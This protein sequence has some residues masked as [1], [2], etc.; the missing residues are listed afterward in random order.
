METPNNIQNFARL[1]LQNRPFA[2]ARLKA[3]PLTPRIQGTVKF[4]PAYSGTLVTAEVV[5]LPNYDQPGPSAPFAFHI[6]EGSSCETGD[7]NNPFT[8]AGG[9]YNPHGL[10]HPFHAGDMPVLFS[11][12]GYAFLAFYTDRFIPREVLG[13]TV[14]IHEKPDDFTTQPAGNAGKRIACG[15]I[16]PY[17]S[18]QNPAVPFSG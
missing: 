10:E 13:R 15:V 18:V 3:G 6:H 12:K 7:Y 14:I 1:M 11:N 16:Q 17:S 4:Y 5:G 8:A 9:H 2:A